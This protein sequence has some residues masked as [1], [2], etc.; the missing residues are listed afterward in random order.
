MRSGLCALVIVMAWSSAAAA[1]SPSLDDAP[2]RAVQFVDKHEGWAVGDNGVIWH[3]IDGGDTWERQPSGVHASLRD[4]QFLDA[5]TGIVVGHETLADGRGSRGVILYTRD[6][7]V[8]W[9]RLAVPAL[10]GLCSVEFLDRR[11]AFVAGAPS[12]QFPTGVFVTRDGGLTWK[13]V[14]GKTTGGGLTADFSSSDLGIVGGPN[15]RLD[16]FRRGELFPAE[17]DPLGSRAVRAVLLRGQEAWAVGDGGLLL[18]S[19]TPPGRRWGYAEVEIP[20]D[21]AQCWD[22]HAIFFHGDYGWVAGRPGSVILHTWD[23][24]KHWQIQSTGQP[25]A[26]HGIHFVSPRRGWAVGDLGT[27]LATRDGGKTWKVQRRGG[28][29]AAVLFISSRAKTLPSATLA[30]LGAEQGYLCTAIQVT[31]TAQRSKEVDSD[32]VELRFAEAIRAVGGC[33]GE[34]LWQFPLPPYASAAKE[35]DL[36]RW[37]GGSEDPNKASE[38]LQ[39][40]IVLAMRIWRPDVVITDDPEP[41]SAA[42]PLGSII[43]LAVKRAFEQAGKADAFPEQIAKLDLEPWNP[44][45]LYARWSR[46]DGAEVSLS[47]QEPRPML[48]KPPAT[49]ARQMAW[50]LGIND[51]VYT[52]DHYRLLA[53]RIPDASSHRQLMAGVQLRPGG[54]ARREKIPPEPNGWDEVVKAYRQ[55]RDFHAIT[56]HLADD[57]IKSRQMPAVVERS[58]AGLPDDMAAEALF[59]LGRAYVRQGQ[60]PMAREIFLRLVDRYPAHRL[61]P[62]ACRWLIQYGSS[63][64]ARRREER[65]QFAVTGSFRFLPPTKKPA[66]AEDVRPNYLRGSATTTLFQRRDEVRQWFKSSLAIADILA[67]HGPLYFDD[68]EIQFCLQSARRQLGE[69]DDAQLWYSRYKLNHS[70]G[71]WY[72]A[73]SAEVWLRSRIG[74]CPKPVIPALTAAEPPYLDG[75]LKEPLWARSDPARLEDASGTTALSHATE[76]W[77]AYDQDFLPRRPLSSSEGDGRAP[78]SDQP[79]PRRRPQPVGPNQLDPRFGPRLLDIL[80]FP[81]RPSRPGLRGL[82]GRSALEPEVVRGGALRRDELAA[83]SSDSARRADGGADP[84]EPDLGGQHRPDHSPER[85]TSGLFACRYPPRTRWSGA[86]ALSAI[87]GRP[88]VTSRHLAG[89]RRSQPFGPIGEAAVVA[90]VSQLRRYNMSR[91]PLTARIGGSPVVRRGPGL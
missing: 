62:A 1:Y 42:G 17:V 43:S 8:K 81:D 44:Q 77:L 75:V 19:R 53:S 6:G 40:Q 86:G 48:R 91:T 51:P 60:W 10:P 27:I 89:M 25:M 32:L 63:S 50:M 28:H 5:F 35:N 4:V 30:L 78:T 3:T 31:T 65:R 84:G 68:P 2:L 47:L 49:L 61:T 36:L 11:T 55:Q 70:V 52:V 56:L 23:G 66:L 46:A 22:F 79:P 57:P 69:I 9:K 72:D 85:D 7:G 67:A 24:G 74:L 21:V 73:A 54:Q 90:A 14:P 71:P 26:L 59:G 83:R 15:G 76:A 41:E 82:L 39:R 80:S 88:A 12:G 18:H 13:P 20:P 37:L 64:E 45:K 29:R 87:A 58:L 16:L 38:R 33:A 34:T